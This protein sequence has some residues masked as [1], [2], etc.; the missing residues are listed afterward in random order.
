MKL[1]KFKAKDTD[2]IKV[3]ETEYY[4]D[5]LKISPWLLLIKN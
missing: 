2:V 5:L 4:Y 1:F 3:E